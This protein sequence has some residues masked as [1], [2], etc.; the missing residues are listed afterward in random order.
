MPSTDGSVDTGTTANGA[1][2][3]GNQAGTRVAAGRVSINIEFKG[4]Q[5]LH[6]Y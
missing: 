1:V 5:K 3:A 6:P 2:T 4:W